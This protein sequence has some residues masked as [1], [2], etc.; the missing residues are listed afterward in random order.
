MEHAKLTMR[1]R[2]TARQRQHLQHLQQQCLAQR[3]RDE[4]EGG[5]GREGGDGKARMAVPVS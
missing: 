3:L 1:V 2:P 5:E 4:R